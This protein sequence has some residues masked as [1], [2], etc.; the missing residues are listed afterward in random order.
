MAMSAIGPL[1]QAAFFGP[2]VA[3]G[4]LRTL[5]DLQLAPAQSLM[6]LFDIWAVCSI[7]SARA[8]AVC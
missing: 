6:T 8:I 1:R 2:T 7:A 5:L 3:G 4:A